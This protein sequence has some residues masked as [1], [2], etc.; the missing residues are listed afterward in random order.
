MKQMNKTSK[1]Q[2]LQGLLHDMRTLSSNLAYFSD[3]M[4]SPEG[5]KTLKLVNTLIHRLEGLDSK[6]IH[7]FLQEEGIKAKLF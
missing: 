1:N 6:A 3:K 4:R 5:E 7:K 2:D